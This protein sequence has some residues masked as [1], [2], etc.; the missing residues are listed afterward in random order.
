MAR[1]GRVALQTILGGLSGGLAG[2][3]RQQEIKKRDLANK[4]ELERRQ[5]MDLISIL[6]AG[7]RPEGAAPAPAG[8][9]PED[10][11][12][13]GKLASKTAPPQPMV[14]ET[15]V[16]V[17]GIGRMMIGGLTPAERRAQARAEATAEAER[18]AREKGRT[19]LQDALS[20]F[21]E[22]ELPQRYRTAVLS[23]ATDLESALAQVRANRPSP[24]PTER[25][26]GMRE[27]NESVGALVRSMTLSGV[28]ERDPELGTM[29]K[30]RYTPE[31]ISNAAEEYRR[32]L[33]QL[34]GIAGGPPAA[35]RGGAAPAGAAP[36]GRN[37]FNLDLGR[38]GR[39]A[40]LQPD[41][42][43]LSP[44]VQRWRTLTGSELP[45]PAGVDLRAYETDANYRRMVNKAVN[46]GVGTRQLPEE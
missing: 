27:V 46:R 41:T 6:Q 23:G 28:E 14:Q 1:G 36:G 31:E 44:N 38:G 19:A 3:A 32:T 21:T 39:P 9:A 12:P 25:P 13:G 22:T 5:A 20:G 30:R 11:G 10:I 4:Q 2:Y 42:R 29:V 24:G 40:S 35:V 34:W 26:L 43:N 45:M 33:M 15:A 17:P 37:M 7:G 8:P 16:D 18:G